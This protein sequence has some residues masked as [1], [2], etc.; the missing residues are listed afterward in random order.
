MSGH[1]KRVGE[2]S[3]HESPII[4]SDFNTENYYR[5][6]TCNCSHGGMCFETDC[7][8]KAETNIRIKTL[9]YLPDTNG[10]EAYRFYEAKVK[11]CRDLP[12][13]EAPRYGVG[14]QYVVKSQ[15]IEGPD[16]PCSLCGDI[17]P[18]GK[19]HCVE[20]FVYL[21]SSC[22]KHYQSLPDG[23]I[24]KGVMDFLMGNVI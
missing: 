9:N 5:G 15:N 1:I 22:F 4:W 20:E 6:Q 8:A 24:K 11:W 21:C 14:V 18:H 23:M 16:Y 3:C 2:R 7:A 13:A 10:P 17:I 19:I 12:A